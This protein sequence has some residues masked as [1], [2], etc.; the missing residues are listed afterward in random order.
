MQHRFSLVLVAIVIA[1]SPSGELPESA[2]GE[3]ARFVLLGASAPYDSVLLGQP[4]TSA[5]KYGAREG[6]TVSRLRQNQ[7]TGLDAIV[8]H[9]NAAGLV[10]DVEFAYHARRDIPALVAGLRSSLGEPIANSVETVAGS[11]RSTLRWCNEST[12]FLITT[13]VPP[14][15]DSIGAISLLRDRTSTLA[16]SGFTRNCS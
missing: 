3:I 5:A 14:A 4:W 15:A 1:C 13:V 9:R 11:T 12:L 16:T 7:F 2:R 10:T 6:E 8:V